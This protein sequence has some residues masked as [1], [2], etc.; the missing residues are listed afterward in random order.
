VP[1]RDVVSKL[2]KDHP[3]ATLGDFRDVLT[4]ALAM[5]RVDAALYDAASKCQEQDQFSKR[6]KDAFFA[7]RPRHVTH[8]D[9]RELRPLTEDDP[10]SLHNHLALMGTAPD[11]ELILTPFDPK[12]PLGPWQATSYLPDDE[13]SV[14]KREEYL[15]KLRARN[16]EG[17]WT[18]VKNPGYYNKYMDCEDDPAA[19]M[20]LFA[21]E[22]PYKV[23]VPEKERV[24]LPPRAPPGS[25]DAVAKFSASLPKGL[26]DGTLSSESEEEDAS[27]FTAYVKRAA[28]AE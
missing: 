15:R 24:P 22:D 18:K 9:G 21:E 6:Q 7:N 4:S 20:R 12:D 17:A 28:K 19:R 11:A 1:L 23:Q 10:P 14:T 26:I 13:E 27:P 5:S 8:L 2:F 3:D 25:L 16:I